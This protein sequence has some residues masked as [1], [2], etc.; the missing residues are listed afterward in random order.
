LTAA[1]RAIKTWPKVKMAA[2]GLHYVMLGGIIVA[3]AL[4]RVTGLNR[5]SLWFDEADVVVRA[6]RPLGEVLRT[7]TAAGENGPVYNL[8]LWLW[9]RVAGVSE[10]AV[11]FPSAVAGAI[12]IPLIYM[13]GKRIAGRTAGLV[14]AGLLAVNPYHVWYSQ[15]AKMYAFV[16][17]LALL[18]SLVLIEALNRNTWST[19]IPYIVITSLMFYTHVTTV[20]IFVAQSLFVLAT[21]KTWQGRRRRWL[22]SV[23]ALTLPYIPI[24]LWAWTVVGGGAR[25][26]QPAVTLWDAVRIVGV[27]FAANR[28]DLVIEQRSSIL[29]LLL[30]LCGAGTL[31]AK[32]RWRASGIFL[33]ALTV[34]PILGIYLVSIRNSV[35][36]DR[37]VIVALPTYLILAAAGVVVLWRSRWLWPVGVVALV[38][39]TSYSWA[40]LRDVNLSTDA[41]KE[42]W[43]SAY[44]LI[45]DQAQPDD[46][47]L[48]HPGYMLTTYQYYS[49][50]DDRLKPYEVATIPTFRVNWLDER[51]MVEQIERQVG[52]PER[53]WFVESPDRILPED[54]DLTLERWLTGHS[55]TL[56]ERQVNGV[57]ITLFEIDWNE[58]DP[59]S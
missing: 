39:M 23:A 20:L 7:F 57:H 13:L 54:Q 16:V 36:S 28:S 2:I 14:A 3:G 9:I 21:L 55:D 56:L 8:F 26:W 15:E 6:Q 48:L 34:I 1:I 38:M 12:A 29:L 31:L 45:A 4:I 58:Y 22:I 25:L 32:Q 59:S 43:R 33:L 42:D 50:R 52:Q 35:F 40:T 44:A 51:I 46:V 10:I 53:I 24:A 47:I 37:Y 5:Q 30:A 27:K 11:R 18:S 41:E 17:V 19:W 49:Q